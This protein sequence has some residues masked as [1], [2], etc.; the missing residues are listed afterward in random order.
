M[1]DEPDETAFTPL[2]IPEVVSMSELTLIPDFWTWGLVATA[3]TTNSFSVYYAWNA[4]F[5][6]I[7]S[8]TFLWMQAD[9]TVFTINIL[10]Y[11]ATVM[12]KQVI[13]TTC[14]QIRW[15]RGCQTRGMSFLSF[16]ALSSATPIWGLV[17]LLFS[18]IPYL[19][20][21]TAHGLVHRA[22][23]FQW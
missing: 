15:S 14:D 7:A 1:P 16:L 10:L 22:W 23:S 18:P 6:A 11:I 9:T 21:F 19:S 13:N 17:H 8:K 20:S 12:V 4:A 3:I 5:H 2:P